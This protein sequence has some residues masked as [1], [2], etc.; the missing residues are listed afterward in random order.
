M[1]LV[2][3]PWMERSILVGEVLHVSSRNLFSVDQTLIRIFSILRSDGV[4]CD[5]SLNLWFFFVSDILLWCKRPTILD[6]IL[7]ERCGGYTYSSGRFISFVLISFED[8]YTLK[9]P[10]SFMLTATIIRNSSLLAPSIQ[11]KYSPRNHFLLLFFVRRVERRET[12][13]AEESDLKEIIRKWRFVCW[14][15]KFFW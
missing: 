9:Q 2:R 13:K 6:M 11:L 8:A 10:L 1:A 12:V 5:S 14:M 7:V 4:K 15:T 3:W